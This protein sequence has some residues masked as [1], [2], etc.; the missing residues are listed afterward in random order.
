MTDIPKR[1]FVYDPPTD[2]PYQIIHQTKDYLVLNKPAG[3][4]SVPGRLS[5]F[6]DSLANRVQK[7]FPSATVVHRLD[8]ATSGIIIMPLNREMHAH[9]GRQFEQRTVSKAYI[10]DVWGQPNLN[11]GYIEAPMIVDWPNRPRQVV[12][13]ENGKP[14]ITKYRIMERNYDHCRL[15]LKPVTGRTH[16]LRVHMQY[17]GNPILGD[18]LYA[19]DAAYNNF[20]RLHLHAAKI[21][22]KDLSGNIMKFSVLPDFQLNG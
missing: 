12:D 17:I 5:E 10:A 21:M 6:K 8:L 4:L 15:L 2:P 11:R 18:E 16:Q 19:P 3:L 22:F 14:A 13:F 1:P 9:L 20:E 7:D